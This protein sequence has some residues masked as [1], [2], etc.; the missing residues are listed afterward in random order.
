LIDIGLPLKKYVSGKI[1]RGVLTGL[2]KA[3]VIDAKT[4]DTLINEDPKCEEIIKPFLLGRNIKRYMPLKPEEFLIFI[5]KGWTR[6]HMDSST[7]PWVCFKSTYPAIANRLEPYSEMGKKRYDK[8]EFWWELRACEYY[9]EFEKQKIMLPDISLRG[10]FTLDET[11]YMYCVNTSYI[12]GS[13]DKYLLG[14]LNSFLMIFFYKNLSSSYRGAYLRY[15]YQYMIQ[16]PIKKIDLDNPDDV[17]KH[18]KMVKLVEMMLDLHK[19]LAAAKI[20]DEKT[21]IQRQIDATDKQIDNLVYDLY[22]LTD[23]EIAIVESY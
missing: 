12:I 10:N 14:I 5:P 11:G 13:S 18:D 17:E 16:M 19:Q 9:N 2:N 6:K 3:F 22:G 21:R 1:F 7:N 23:E 8:G 15:I 20:P 4:R